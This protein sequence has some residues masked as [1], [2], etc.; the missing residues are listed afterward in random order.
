[1]AT[2]SKKVFLLRY[3]PALIIN[4]VF[5]FWMIYSVH[6]ISSFRTCLKPIYFTD[7]AWNWYVC[8]HKHDRSYTWPTILYNQ[9]LESPLA[10]IMAGIDIRKGYDLIE[11]NQ[12]INRGLLLQVNRLGNLKIIVLRNEFQWK[13]I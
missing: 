7:A 3:K 12:C 11:H 8:T 2:D 4:V 1:M 5:H 10:T 9:D 6:S 13:Y